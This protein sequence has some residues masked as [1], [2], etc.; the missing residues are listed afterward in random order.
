[1]KLNFTMRKAVK[2]QREK[3][4]NILIGSKALENYQNSLSDYFANLDHLKMIEGGHGMKQEDGFTNIL[5]DN[6]NVIFI[7]IPPNLED[8]YNHVKK[9]VKYFIDT[10]K[11]VEL[12]ARWDTLYET[13]EYF[14]E[15][16]INLD[17]L[18]I[19]DLEYFEQE[20]KLFIET[21]TK[22]KKSD[23]KGKKEE[24]QGKS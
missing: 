22:P 17:D 24:D 19:K 4:I 18:S 14:I 3:N 5:D 1:M 6:G 13:I 21:N 20:L 15:D 10:Y 16:E 9:Q 2:L 7:N 8:E 12:L 11:S 23:K